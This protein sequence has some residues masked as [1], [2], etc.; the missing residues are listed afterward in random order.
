MSP[1]FVCMS[2]PNPIR[3]VLSFSGLVWKLA[4]SRSA[5]KQLRL[6]LGRQ[7]FAPPRPPDDPAFVDVRNLM[8]TLTIEELNES[9]EEYFR[10][11]PDFSPYLSKP[12]SDV[13]EMSE[14]LITFAQ[15]VNGLNAGRGSDVLDFGSG[16]CWST[17][18]LV[19]MGYATTAMDVSPTALEIGRELFRRVPCV[20]PHVPPQFEVFD[21]RHFNLPDQSFDRIVCLNAFH[22][23][24]N[25][26]AVLKEMA[27]VLRPGGIAGFSEPGTGH[28]YSPQAQHD[29]QNFRV[30]ENDI[31]IDAI[32]RWA[33]EA[34]FSWLELA[35]VD[36]RSY[37]VGWQEYSDLIAGGVSAERYVDTVRI[38][39]LNRRVFFLHKPGE[40]APDS[41]QRRGL[42][43]VVRVD[44][45]ATRVTAGNDFHGDAYVENTG[46]N[47]WLSSGAV[48]GPVRIGV[49]L[50]S[51]DGK[52][53]DHDF[54][55][56]QLPRALR[57]GESAA[58]RFVVPAPP[59]G[60][61]RF[62]FDLVSENVCWFSENGARPVP[63]DV[64]VG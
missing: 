51:R 19:Q 42:N 10:L 20:G 47:A 30:V 18:F 5:R 6:I 11:H 12:F 26:E 39:A 7:P 58:F 1:T 28:S 33:T 22:H 62:I 8:A 41:R 57:P 9:A 23:V 48:F 27:R 15:V 4:K 17:R 64:S 37:R 60:D 55:R 38:A 56:V 3:R 59:P 32:E 44:L 25:P 13:T 21:G 24:P 63:V 14:Q 29:M 16:A 36:A 54:A 43:G 52:R 31:D 50:F 34:G 53:I 49:H 61:Y 2:L 46:T 35:V 40:T 45:D